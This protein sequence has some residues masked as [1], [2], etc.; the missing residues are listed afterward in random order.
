MRLA[1]ILST[2]ACL[3][4]SATPAGAALVVV[5][6]HDGAP[7][8][9]AHTAT[10]PTY[11]TRVVH[12]RRLGPALRR[13]RARRDV[14][15]AVPDVSAHAA[16]FIPDD[17]G[18][19][20]TP[21]GWAKVQ[22]NFTGPFGVGAPGAW[23]NLI[24]D[25]RPGGKGVVVAVL[26]TGVAY[27]SRN[28]GKLSPDL[29]QT[30][31]V[32]GW[33]FVHNDPYA[34]DVNGHGT[35]VASTIAESTNN[36]IGLTGLAYGASIMPVQV[37][38]SHGDGGA[39]TIA[40]GVRFAADHGAQVINLS[41]EFSPGVTAGQIPEL[42]DALDYAHRKGV[43]IAAASG[44]EA[45]TSIAYPAKTS[46]VVSVGSTTEHGCVSDFS[47]GG[48]NLDIVAPGG[49]SDAELPDDPNCHP[50][51]PPG[52]DIYQETIMGAPDHRRFGIPGGYAGTS[53]ATP[54]VAAAAALVIASGVL[55]PDP[56]PDAIKARLLST[57]RPLGSPHDHVD[58][59]A[60][61]LDA[62]A[63]T[64]PIATPTT[65][66]TPTTPATPTTPTTATTPATT[67]KPATR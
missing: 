33:D 22:W 32:A 43:F 52:H 12:V 39:A 59:G 48:R 42:I 51:A 49:G 11:H 7:G 60:G 15:Y 34:Q 47:N 57:A 45:S 1:L 62:A 36:G 6:F 63:A 5:R 61:L 30:H 65:P 26:D 27:S 14:E 31:F 64:A 44:N 41:L 53:M 13:L 21:G 17:P 16:D 58:Y 38:D 56:S 50:D 8:L 24:A 23:S 46:V 10:A 67:P 28:D 25:G 18:R 40:R 2:L 3:L 35:H 29:R 54:H 19:G 55:G 20:R 66:T 9:G 4:A 37:L